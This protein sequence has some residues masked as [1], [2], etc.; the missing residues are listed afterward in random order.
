MKHLAPVRW[1]CL[2]G[3]LAVCGQAQLTEWATTVQPGKFLL[4]MDVL[5]L[6]FDHDGGDRYTG[7][8]V[9]STFLTTGLTKDWDVQV[10]AELFLNQ[11]F[12]S[13]GLTD[14][15]SGIGDIYL[16]TKW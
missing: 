16:R 3:L 7:V 13:G 8:G 10:G 6:T 1:L 15:R 12:D 9:A 14:R 11:Q 5:S 4:K 2:T